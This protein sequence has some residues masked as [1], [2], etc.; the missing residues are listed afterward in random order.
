MRAHALRTVA[1]SVTL[2]LAAPAAAQSVRVSAD[3]VERVHLR[4]SAT[5]VVIGNPAV[6]DVS[7]I[8]PRTLAI[9]GKAPGVTSLVVFDRSRRVLFDGP[10]SVG[11][12]AGRVSMVRG[13]EGGAAEERAYSCNGVCTPKAGR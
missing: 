2:A 10:I 11:V 6:A 9:T 3:Q 1:L 12:E 13:A 5:D 7:L 8:D 4:G